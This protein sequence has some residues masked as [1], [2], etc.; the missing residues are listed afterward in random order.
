[1]PF[2]LRL[3]SDQPFA[4]GIDLGDG[5]PTAGRVWTSQ[6]ANLPPDWTDASI[7]PATSHIIWVSLGG[8]DTTGDG[9]I[10]KPFASINRACTLVRSYGN[11]STTNRYTI[12]VGAGRF[13]ENLVMS[14]W[15]FISG[16]QT[17]ATRVT[18]ASFA[19]GAEWQPNVDHRGGFQNMTVSG[20][21]PVDF[22]AALS[23]QGKLS[24]INVWFADAWTYTARTV[25]NQITLGSCLLSGFTQNGFTYFNVMNCS[26]VNG[27]NVVLNATAGLTATTYFRATELDGTLTLNSV[28]ANF[29]DMIW[30]ASA[31]AGMLTLNGALVHVSGDSTPINFRN[32]VTLAG[33]AADPRFVL[34][35]AKAGNAALASVCT[36]LQAWGGWVDTTT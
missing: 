4:Q 7:P 11:A 23:D 3:G 21:G 28:G 20:G 14:D 18:F 25:N 31:V 34:A 8:S 13:T 26:G 16:F 32:G 9:S 22:N 33:G 6:G 19:F 36:Q 24:F 27:T 5:T 29:C 10:A 15:T 30:L 12:L 2:R 17:E 35:G 1:M